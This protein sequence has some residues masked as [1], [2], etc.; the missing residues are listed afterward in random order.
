M[1]KRFI[2]FTLAVLVAAVLGAPFSQAAPLFRPTI[3]VPN[4]WSLANDVPY[5]DGLAQ[6]DPEG[7]GFLLYISSVNYIDEVRISYEKAQVT[8]YDDS[9][10]TSQAEALFYQNAVAFGLV[11]TGTGEAAGARCGFAKGVNEL[12]NRTVVFKVFIKENFYFSIEEFYESNARSETQ[13]NMLTNSITLD[14]LPSPTPPLTPT[15]SPTTTPT[16]T[17]LD[18]FTLLTVAGGGLVVAAILTLAIVSKR[19]KRVK[20]LKAKGQ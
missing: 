8:S 20:F 7:A 10:L 3:T 13:V 18:N 16:Q 5:P 12:S 2:T 15:Q 1:H 9:S 11:Q 14:G 17:P 19:K 6:F 4:G